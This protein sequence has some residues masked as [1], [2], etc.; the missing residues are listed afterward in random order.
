MI[1]KEFTGC[2][3]LLE[4]RGNFH[5]LFTKSKLMYYS[6]TTNIISNFG[7][8]VFKMYIFFPRVLA[9]GWSRKILDLKELEQDMRLLNLS[10]V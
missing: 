4:L 6:L 7:S 1:L 2:K 10:V 8:C 5:T 9:R 3:R